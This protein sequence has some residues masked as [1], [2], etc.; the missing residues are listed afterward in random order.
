MGDI[1]HMISVITL[2]FILNEDTIIFFDDIQAFSPPGG[3]KDASLS[4]MVLCKFFAADGSDDRLNYHQ[5]NNI[6]D[7]AEQ[8]W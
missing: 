8:F 1:T 6:L 7:V 3:R 4:H 2:H 5:I